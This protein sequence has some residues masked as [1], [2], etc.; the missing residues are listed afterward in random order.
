MI[1]WGPGLGLIWE[2]SNI[3]V[4]IMLNPVPSLDVLSLLIFDKAEIA[5]GSG[6]E[7]QWRGYTSRYDASTDNNR[8][9]QKGII[10]AVVY[11][12]LH[13]SYFVSDI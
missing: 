13:T 5:G 6:L 1:F 12:V 9:T 4:P 3:G 8:G 2:T 11:L 10:K 7:C